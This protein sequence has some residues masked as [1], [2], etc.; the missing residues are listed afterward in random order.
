MFCKQKRLFGVA[1]NNNPFF[2]TISDRLLYRKRYQIICKH[3]NIEPSDRILDIGCGNDGRSFEIYNKSN[4]IVG[5][6]I[7]PYEKIIYNS[8]N[9]TYIKR[10]AVDMSCFK[11]KEFDIAICIGMLEHVG[12]YK[13]R[14]KICKDI[15]R[16]S[17][18]YALF[19]PH[20][21]AFIEPH[22][23]FPFFG[24][25]D[26]TIQYRLIRLFNLHGQNLK[27]LTMQEG[28][29]KIQNNYIWLTSQEWR[30]HLPG[31]RTNL[32]FIGPLLWNL[33]ILK[34]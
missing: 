32:F 25:L 1:I 13:K 6:D 34:N 29:E 10:D 15:E 33:I 26:E 23:K 2:T 28:I 7:I 20:R 12:D 17:K 19:V 22:F 14:S 24:C 8:P 31:G 3:L 9:F 30:R 27:D 21:Y 5:I 18:K 11:D 4:E 16:V